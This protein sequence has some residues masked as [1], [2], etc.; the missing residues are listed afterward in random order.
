MQEKLFDDIETVIS[1]KAHFRKIRGKWSLNQRLIIEILADPMNNVLTVKEISRKT[2]LSDS[3]IYRLKRNEEFMNEV[4]KR[5]K[6][7]D[8][9]VDMRA[10]AWKQLL[11][12][13]AKRPDINLKLLEILGEYI[14]KNELEE[15]L[16]MG[17]REVVEKLQK[18]A[19]Y[20]E[21]DKNGT[22]GGE[23]N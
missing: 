23:N 14:P 22:S 9:L 1:S 11:R 7:S 12:D 16:K 8:I 13:A 15:N 3:Y 5:M 6:S 17:S 20:L 10:R 19:K 4:Q 18:L 2:K 21:K